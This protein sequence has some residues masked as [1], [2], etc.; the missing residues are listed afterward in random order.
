M[1][2]TT[3]IRTKERVIRGET[4]NMCF[5]PVLQSG[6]IVGSD[7]PATNIIPTHTANGTLFYSFRAYTDSGDFILKFGDSGTAELD[8]VSIGIYEHGSL[9]VALEWDSVN[10]YYYGNNLEAA[11]ALEAVVDEKHC[12]TLDVVPDNLQKFT[13][14]FIETE[15]A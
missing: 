2:V 9:T 8:N 7:E 3:G 6:V 4:N 12:F 11:L 5:T 1:F 10:Q 14:E 15:T 13:F